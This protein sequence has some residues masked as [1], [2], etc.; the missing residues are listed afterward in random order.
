MYGEDDDYGIENSELGDYEED[1]EDEDEN[2]EEA[3]EG[4]EGED[5]DPDA[6]KTKKKKKITRPVSVA[7]WRG[8]LGLGGKGVGPRGCTLAHA[9]SYAAL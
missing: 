6:V 3:G 7:S 2:Q 9:H 1:E 5:G 4:E 8:F